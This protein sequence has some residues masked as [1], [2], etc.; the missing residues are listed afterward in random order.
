M[1]SL[2]QPQTSRY[3]LLSGNWQSWRM[4]H[5]IP[6]DNDYDFMLYA[7]DSAGESQRLGFCLPGLTN[8]KSPAR[9]SKLYSTF[10][11][12]G[13]RAYFDAYIINLGYSVA[14]VSP[15]YTQY[16]LTLRSQRMQSL[17]QV[18]ETGKISTPKE[19]VYGPHPVPTASIKAP[20]Q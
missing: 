17:K 18:S 10:T 2:L 8:D 4:F 16:K 12:P 15:E 6:Y 14:S 11:T 3:L 1:Y 19:W 20:P 13:Y 5:S 9:I 7:Y